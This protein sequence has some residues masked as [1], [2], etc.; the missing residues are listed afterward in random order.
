MYP[1]VFS[2]LMLQSMPSVL[3]DSRKLSNPERV[4]MANR[5][6]DSGSG[7]NAADL[8]RAAVAA[9]KYPFEALEREAAATLPSPAGWL[10]A[11][12]YAL[13]LRFDWPADQ[14]K[15]IRHWLAINGE[16]LETI[17]KAVECERCFFPF[18]ADCPFDTSGIESLSRLRR[19]AKL[20]AASAALHAHEGKWDA[21]YADNNIILKI[22]AHAR[23]TPSAIGRMVG[24]AIER[25]GLQQMAVLLEKHPSATLHE[26]STAIVK[27]GTRGASDEAIDWVESAYQW[28]LID[29][30]HAWARDEHAC[31]GMSELVGLFFSADENWR[32]IAKLL[33]PTSQPFKSVEEFKAAVRATTPAQSGAVVEQMNKRYAKWSELPLHE[34]LKL[35]P[36]LRKDTAELTTRDPIW[37][38]WG[39]STA[40]PVGKPTI[41]RQEHEMARRAA[42]LVIELHEM[43]ARTSR[44]PRRLE[45]V[46]QTAGSL[47]LD[48]C[49][50]T[51]LRYVP[52]AD[53]ASFK[54]YSVGDDQH[55]DGG[56]PTK[57]IV[58]W[59]TVRPE[60]E[61][62]NR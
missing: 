62:P 50:G 10:D 39:N 25:M 19:L 42:L 49:S 36:E 22:A 20:M 48:V 37:S 58:F 23:Q 38:L 61:S 26:L 41:Q 15:L 12:E 6:A 21:A 54:L 2:V 35:V 34:A 28:D 30:T 40:F 47:T 11:N 45:E 57:D 3:P 5:L 56:D 32:E 27:A 7:S 46:S 55:D 51:P 8:Y 33:G 9:A 13:T 44:L 16:A 1:I 60:F 52:S 59:P 53:S 31:P 24:N 29:A 14:V 17:R 4:A 18:K 43:R